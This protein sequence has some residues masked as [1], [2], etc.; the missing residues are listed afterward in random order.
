MLWAVA[1]LIVLLRD[2]QSDPLGAAH[3]FMDCIE[4]VTAS[5]TLTC[6]SAIFVDLLHRDREKD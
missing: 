3:T 1:I 4:Y 6:I 2:Y 5:L